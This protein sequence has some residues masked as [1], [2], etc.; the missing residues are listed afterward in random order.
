ASAAFAVWK[1]ALDAKA[2]LPVLLDCARNGDG[3]ASAAAAYAL[4][5]MGLAAR[6]AAPALLD[7]ANELRLHQVVAN[8]CFVQ[9]GGED[10]SLAAHG[11]DVGRKLILEALQ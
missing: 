10:A 7:R 4:K 1:L 8:L 2:A 11:A 9:G 6:P 5:D 3:M